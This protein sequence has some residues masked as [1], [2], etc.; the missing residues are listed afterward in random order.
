KWPIAGFTLQWVNA[1]LNNP[2]ARSALV[3]SVQ[4][5]LIATAIALV[6]GSLLAA[7]VHRY[8]FFGRNVVS[9]LVILPVALPGIV[10]G[11]A[12]NTTFRTIFGGLSLFTLIVGHATFCVVTV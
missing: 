4:V 12:L 11:I 6:L 2:G 1:A 3:L 8:R 5:G 7:A 10:T 9:F